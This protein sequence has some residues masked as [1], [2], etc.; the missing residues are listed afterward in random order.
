MSSKN[1]A[2]RLRDIIDNIEAINAFVA[3]LD[4]QAFQADRKTLYAVLRALEIGSE[5]SRRIPADIQR[6]HPMID[7]TAIAAAGNTPA[8]LRTKS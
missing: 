8:P 4:F 1:P 5:A 3:G 6:R 7:W 2:Q